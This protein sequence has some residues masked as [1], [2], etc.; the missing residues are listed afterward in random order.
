MNTIKKAPKETDNN[1]H[2]PHTYPDMRM[3]NGQQKD[4]HTGSTTCDVCHRTFGTV[5]G[6]R[7]HQGKV[8]RKKTK[9]QGRPSGRQTRGGTS[10]D[11]NHSGDA[12]T[13]VSDSSTPAQ[14][15]GDDS[16]LEDE[17]RRSKV[18]WP[19]AK[20]QCFFLSVNMLWDFPLFEGYLFTCREYYKPIICFTLFEGP[21]FLVV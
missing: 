6:M 2:D 11:T 20:E 17:G 1:D 19:A 8:C 9:T 18:L 7:I 16:A 14:V 15:S 13:P 10:Q 5:R 12:A 21:L 3:N 4:N